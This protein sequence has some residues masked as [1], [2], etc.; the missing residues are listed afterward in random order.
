MH[1]DTNQISGQSVQAKSVNIN[2]MADVF[3][4]FTVVQQIMTEFSGA[5]IEKGNICKT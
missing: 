4:V 2:G 5:A 1:Q 3:L